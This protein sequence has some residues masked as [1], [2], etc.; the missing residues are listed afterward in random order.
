MTTRYHHGNLREALIEAAA[1][2]ARTGGPDAVVLREMAR[3]VGVSHNAAY[4]HFADRDE[5]LV[6]VGAVAMAQLEQAMVDGMAA[7]RTRDPRK[8]A[9]G[10]LSATGRAYVTFALQNPGLFTVAFA[11]V[12]KAADDPGAPADLPEGGPYAV[13]NRVLDEMVEVGAMSVKRRPEADVSCWSAVHGF[14]SLHLSGP[15]E[16]VP[17]ELWRP[18]LE[19]LLATIERGLCAAEVA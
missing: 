17:E 14:A 3:I 16:A 15:L 10:L 13:L 5:V 2:L 1:E 7:V 18:G 6:E 9:R 19:H 11:G 4:R 12:E 8:R